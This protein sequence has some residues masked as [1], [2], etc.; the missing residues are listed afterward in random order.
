MTS[1]LVLHEL[2]GYYMNRPQQ[3]S[4]FLPLEQMVLFLMLEQ[5][6]LFLPLE[7]MIL[8]LTLEQMILMRSRI[9]V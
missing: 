2:L 7:Q 1:Y 9:I 4:L 8:F 5:M 6:I 3:M